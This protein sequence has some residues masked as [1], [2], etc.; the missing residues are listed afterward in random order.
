MSLQKPEQALSHLQKA[1]ALNPEN[2]VSWD[3]FSHVQGVL[4]NTVEQKRA[5]AEFQRLHEKLSNQHA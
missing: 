2:E 3:W 4:A 5:F 1:I